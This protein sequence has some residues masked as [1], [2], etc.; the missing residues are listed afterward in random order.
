MKLHRLN[1]EGLEKFGAYL[2]SLQNNPGTPVPDYLM[3]SPD[4][5][6]LVGESVDIDQGPFATRL[7]VA[8][9]I[10]N[11][12]AKANLASA[13][14]DRGLW[15]WLALAYFDYLC[16]VDNNG[17]RKVGER[18]RYIAEPQN[19]QRY[20]RHLLLG[21]YLIY[22]AHKDDPARALA[23]LCKPPHIIDDVVGQLAA[24]QE[25]VSNRAIMELATILYYDP[26]T[27]QLKRGAGNKGAGTP[28]RLVVIL[29]QFTLTW[30]LY[31]MSVKEL[32]DVLPKEF[33]KFIKA[34]A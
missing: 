18:A 25:L 16:P 17:A 1:S 19:Y 24:S 3:E 6:E 4:Y 22:Q 9:A 30:D 15:A 32:L 26:A 14:R 28:R 34:R 33:R 20:Y 31:S 8:E 5:S 13:E 2:D 10:D 12:F 27:K 29:K 11:L 21:P 23:L 7:S